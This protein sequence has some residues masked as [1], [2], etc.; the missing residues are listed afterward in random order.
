MPGSRGRKAHHYCTLGL[1]SH[2]RGPSDVIFLSRMFTS[3]RMES[4]LA[5]IC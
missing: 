2:A 3:L 4:S 1:C 5:D